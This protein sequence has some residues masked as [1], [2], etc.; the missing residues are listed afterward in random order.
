MNPTCEIK[1]EIFKG[2]LDLLLHLI[3]KNKLDI[4]DLP[5]S[6]VTAQY[7]EYLEIMKALNIV[8]AGEYLFIAA[9]L[10]HIKSKILIPQLDNNSKEDEDP[11]LEIVKPLKEFIV[12]KKIASSLNEQPIL[13]RDVFLQTQNKNQRPQFRSIIK[14]SNP[15]KIIKALQSVIRRNRPA[16]APPVKKSK[17]T[18]NEQIKFIL[19]RL[20]TSNSINLLNIIPPKKDIAIAS[21]L[22][23]LE[24]AKDKKI[25]ISQDFPYQLMIS[26]HEKVL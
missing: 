16:I 5:I 23:V 17:I 6:L 26:K 14:I 15:Y 12:I 13:G 8:V 19:K 1:L 11:R 25:K 3:N 22:A 10:C 2:P 18:I 20:T 9:T 21:F 4:T 7:L 24:L